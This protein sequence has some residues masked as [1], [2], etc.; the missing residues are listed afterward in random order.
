MVMFLYWMFIMLYLAR[1]VI[2]SYARFFIII[3][4]NR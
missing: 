3:I 1:Y 2:L 4:V